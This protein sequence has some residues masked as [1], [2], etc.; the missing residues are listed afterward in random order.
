MSFRT[1][2]S[3]LLLAGIWFYR[4]EPQHGKG[5]FVQMPGLDNE[6]AED[7]VILAPINCPS[8]GAQRADHLARA[9]SRKGIPYTRANNARLRHGESAG[10]DQM[11]KINAVMSGE[12]PIVF[13][14]GRA[15]AN[16]SLEEVI[17]EYRSGER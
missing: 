10:R 3:L 7:V 14:R 9:L 13:V 4:M 1:F 5:E 12:V 8:A 2:V 15:K 11:A 16:P 17:S 6:G